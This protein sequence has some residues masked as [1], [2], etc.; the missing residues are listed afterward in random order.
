MQRDASRLDF[1]TGVVSRV[2]GNGI[3]HRGRDGFLNSSDFTRHFVEPEDLMHPPRRRRIAGNP[4]DR[5]VV[6]WSPTKSEPGAEPAS[7]C[8]TLPTTTHTVA[9]TRR[10]RVARDFSARLDAEAFR[11]GTQSH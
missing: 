4:T 9:H 7:M 3:G 5:F 6:G 10:C 8:S 11:P 2:S 1:V